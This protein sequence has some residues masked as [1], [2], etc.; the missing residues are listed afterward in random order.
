MERMTGSGEKTHSYVFLFVYPSFSSLCSD[1][2][3]GCSGEDNARKTSHDLPCKNESHDVPKSCD[4]LNTTVSCDHIAK[5]CDQPSTTESC[6]QPSTAEPCDQTS[7]AKSCDLPSVQDSSTSQC[8]RGSVVDQT[9]A[10]CDADKESTHLHPYVGP[11]YPAGYIRVTHSSDGGQCDI[12]KAKAVEL[13]EHY[14]VENPDCL[15]LRTHQ[16]SNNRL[17]SIHGKVSSRGGAKESNKGRD[18]KA[19]TKNNSGE[20]YEKSVAKH[21]DVAFMKFQK[22]LDKCPRQLLRYF[23]EDSCT[24]THTHTT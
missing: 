22:E 3:L 19:V 1:E 7:I 10:A 13:L 9:S 17:S 11:A 23:C 16:T 15:L 6:D 2:T 24:H 18:L 8:G 4:Q 5:S 12:N 20:A 21:G 14:S